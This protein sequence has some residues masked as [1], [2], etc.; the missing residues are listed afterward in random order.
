MIEKRFTTEIRARE[1]HLEGYAARFGVEARIGDFTEVIA[2]GAFAQSL[3]TKRDILALVDHDASKVLAR[4]RSGTLKLAEDSNGLHF[5][6]SL[7]N[8]QP[9]NDILE[10]VTRGDAGGASFAFTIEPS[11]ERWTGRRRE[12]RSVTLH[13]I[14]IVSSFAAYPNTVVIARAKTPRLNLARLY[15]ET[16]GPWGY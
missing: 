16:V 13:E 10:L 15:L 2:A 12:L 6:L 7:P 11:G 4:T 14:S 3:S 9:A 8:T 5:D 1:R